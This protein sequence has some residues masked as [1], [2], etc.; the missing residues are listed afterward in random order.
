[1][2]PGDDASL[3]W[4]LGDTIVSTV[5][6]HRQHPRES[7]LPRIPWADAPEMARLAVIAHRNR[8]KQQSE[9]NAYAD[10][11][12]KKGE[13][14]MLA[15]LRDTSGPARL[16]HVKKSRTSR[17]LVM[18]APTSWYED[19]TMEVNCI[20]GGLACALPGQ[21]DRSDA[22]VC[23]ICVWRLN[24]LAQ[25]ETNHHFRHRAKRIF[26]EAAVL[27]SRP[28]DIREQLVRLGRTPDERDATLQRVIG[29]L[30]D[31]ASREEYTGPHGKKKIR[32]RRFAELD[33]LRVI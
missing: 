20:V 14:P 2:R 27:I 18:Y 23:D 11:Q 4:V 16:L 7:G 9:I 33:C 24:E 30:G 13:A 22:D 12:K 3:G 31:R 25:V 19:F 26:F 17:D 5:P 21:S 8:E 10:E 1:M 6:P 15:M 32:I 28:E 29:I